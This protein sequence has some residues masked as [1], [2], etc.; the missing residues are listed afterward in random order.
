MTLTC[1]HPTGSGGPCERA[2]ADE[3]EYCFMHSGNG[4]P[5]GHGAPIGNQNAVGNSGGGAPV[6]NTNAEVYGSWSDPL[7]EYDRLDGEKKEYVDRLYTDLLE[8]SQADLPQQKR[9]RKARQLAVLMCQSNRGWAHAMANDALS[10]ARERD[11]EGGE[12]VIQRRINPAIL[13]DNR[14]RSKLRKLNR[15]LRAYPSSDGRPCSE[16]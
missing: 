15:E 11:L 4:T 7:K 12:T 1:G 9:E 14:N 2:V 10:V 5:P 16:Q 13:A 3:G 6:G 8:R